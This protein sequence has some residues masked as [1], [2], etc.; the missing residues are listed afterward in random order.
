MVIHGSWRSGFKPWPSGGVTASRAKGLRFSI[1]S[2]R[3]KGM[4]R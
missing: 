2:M 1:M 3:K 4:P